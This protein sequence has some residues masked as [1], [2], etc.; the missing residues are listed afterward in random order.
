MRKQK[1]KP[2]SYKAQK[3]CKKIEDYVKEASKGLDSDVLDEIQEDD[4]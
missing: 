1:Y 4:E 3:S 2:I